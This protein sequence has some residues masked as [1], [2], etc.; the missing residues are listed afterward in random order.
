MQYLFVNSNSNLNNEE[1]KDLETEE[2][3]NSIFSQSYVLYDVSTPQFNWLVNRRY[4]DFIW[5]RDCLHSLFP[6]DILPLLPKK[7]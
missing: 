3:N 1:Q 4:S 7:K 5:L 2:I 6:C